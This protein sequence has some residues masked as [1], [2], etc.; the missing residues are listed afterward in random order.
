[1][2]SPSRALRQNPAAGSCQQRTHRAPLARRMMR[3]S[4]VLLAAFGVAKIADAQVTTCT[5][6]ATCGPFIAEVSL[7][8][9]R[10]ASCSPSCQH[11]LRQCSCRSGARRT[12][13]GS[14]TP[15]RAHLRLRVA[16]GRGLLQQQ[17]PRASL[18]HTLT[19]ATH[20][21]VFE[22]RALTPSAYFIPTQE[23]ANPTDTDIALDG[24][25]FPNTSNAPAVPGEFEYWYAPPA[26]DARACPASVHRGHAPP[27]DGADAVR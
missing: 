17:V 11:V 1:M 14:P 19:S 18:P 5:A 7:S 20:L 23:F 3:K 22:S 2:R 12:R 10:T 21:L 25:G 4:A 27:R 8:S 16:G 26:V 6:S 13:P 15:V 24:Y 9:P